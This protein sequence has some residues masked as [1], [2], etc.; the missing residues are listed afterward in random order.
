M[1]REEIDRLINQIQKLMYG[2]NFEVT[3]GIEIFENCISLA[4]VNHAIKI[5]FP[6]ANV[7]SITP[8]PVTQQEFWDD[9]NEKFD[10]RGDGIGNY[11]KLSIEKETALKLKQNDLRKFI[12]EY[13]IKDTK[14]Y[15]YPFLEGIPGYPVY[16]EYSFVLLNINS[17]SIF[18]YGSS[19]D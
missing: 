10:Y 4:D 11:L 16:W 17:K 9:I 19:S 15:S 14:I 6:N 12:S 8:I 3:L 18:L 13:R 5:T 7:E 2:V 1:T